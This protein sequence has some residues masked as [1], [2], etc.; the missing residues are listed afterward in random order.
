M[1]H[2]AELDDNNVVLQVIVVNNA[3]C[4]DENGNESEAVGIAFCQSLFGGRWLQTSYNGNFRKNYAEVGGTYD[5]IDD[6]FLLVKPF[7]SWVLD[8]NTWQWI[9]PVPIPEVSYGYCAYWDEAQINWV[10]MKIDEGQ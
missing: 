9:A 6:A 4:L 8:K 7:P 10:V 5:P 2:F 3:D 1:A